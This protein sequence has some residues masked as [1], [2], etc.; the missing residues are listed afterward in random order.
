MSP[1]KMGPG[2]LL[3]LTKAVNSLNLKWFIQQVFLKYL[4]CAR[5]RLVAGDS[6]GNK[7]DTDSALGNSSL[8]EKQAN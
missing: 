1:G 2:N 6:A 8:A 5:P 3:I 7:I 4:L